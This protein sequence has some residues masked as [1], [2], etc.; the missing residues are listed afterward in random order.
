MPAGLHRRLAAPLVV[1]RIGDPKGAFPIYSGEGARRVSGRW[2]RKGQA[3]ISAS[4]SYSTA[5]LER[6]VHY[7]GK[8]PRGQHY[9]E[10][11]IPVGTAYEVVTGHGLPRWDEKECRAA[12]AFGAKWF[13]EG[14]SA[15]L[16]VPSVVARMERN[17]LI[18]PSHAD[19]SRISPG[20]E[21]PVT[22]D[23]RLF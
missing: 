7:S 14:R 21:I 17:V 13:D 8:L 18:N 4:V 2:H 16:L 12:R 3:V 9:I 23:A 11:T 19:S 10:I 6:L 15:I 1:Y 22:W 5:M 20:L